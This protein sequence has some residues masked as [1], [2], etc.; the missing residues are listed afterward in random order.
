[1]ACIKA[2]VFCYEPVCWGSGPLQKDEVEEPRS[3]SHFRG[4]WIISGRNKNWKPRNEAIDTFYETFYAELHLVTHIYIYM[5]IYIYVYSL[6]QIYKYV[7][8]FKYINMTHI[9]DI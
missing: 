4:S 5:Y 9:S 7:P 1:M 6:F 8:Y 3:A 2:K